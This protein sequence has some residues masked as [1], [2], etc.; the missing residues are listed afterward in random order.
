[1][2][3]LGCDE[4]CYIPILATS[5]KAGLND[6]LSNIPFYN[7]QSLGAAVPGVCHSLSAPRYQDPSLFV[8]IFFFTGKVPEINSFCSCHFLKLHHATLTHAANWPFKW[9]CSRMD[10]GEELGLPFGAKL[11]FG[12]L[13]RL[14]SMEIVWKL[15]SSDSILLISHMLFNFPWPLCQVTLPGTWNVWCL[16]S[17]WARCVWEMLL[18]PNNG[19]FFRSH[20]LKS[21]S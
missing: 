12:Q 18:F 13:G 6:W 8:P 4:S 10:L 16:M 21:L 14:C 11:C 15:F 2:S 9:H 7:F 19:S 17:G 20:T 1:M 3:S 5:H